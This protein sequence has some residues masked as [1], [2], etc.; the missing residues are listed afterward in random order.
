MTMMCLLDL[1]VPNYLFIHVGTAQDDSS[2]ITGDVYLRNDTNG[3][4]REMDCGVSG[5]L[6]HMLPDECEMSSVLFGD[7]Q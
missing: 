6:F 7:C 4:K 1:I 5:W 2:L 3:S